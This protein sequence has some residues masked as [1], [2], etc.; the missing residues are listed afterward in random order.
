MVLESYFQYFHSLSQNSDQGHV[1]QLL[2]E[3]IGKAP[4]PPHFAPTRFISSHHTRV[5]VHNPD[6]ELIFCADMF[7]VGT[8]MVVFGMGLHLLF[9]GS[10]RMQGKGQWP[11]NSNLFG[12][13]YL[14]VSLL[15]ICLY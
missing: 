9:V 2:F 10:E 13:S 4:H 15:S 7:L 12:L 8:V 5:S 14:R 11:S 6:E 1:M 3:A